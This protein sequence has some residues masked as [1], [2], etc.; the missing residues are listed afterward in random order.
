MT[1]ERSGSTLADYLA[2]LRQRKLL[3]IV[4]AVLCAAAGLGFS[5]LQNKE[6]DATSS[7]ALRDLS[8][9]LTLLGGFASTPLTP[10]QLASAHVPLVTRNSVAAE[11]KT[12]LASPLTL[13]QL[14]SRV[15]VHVD[16]N[17][18]L[19]LISAHAGTGQQAAEIANAFARVDARRSTDLARAR[20]VEQGK[21]L[22]ERL[23]TLDREKDASQRLVISQQLER[24]RSLSAVAQPVRVNQLA[25]VPSSPSSPKPARNTIAGLLFGIFLGIALAYGREALDQRLRD[26]TQVRKLLGLPIVGQVETS[27]L[28]AGSPERKGRRQISDADRE[29]LRILRQNTKNLLLDRELRSVVVTSGMPQEGK[30]SVAAGIAAANAATGRRTLLIECDLRRPVL[31]TRLGLNGSPGLTDYLSGDATPQEVL[32]QVSPDAA[33]AGPDST[34]HF[35][36]ITAG[37]VPM[38]PELMLASER[39]RKLLADVAQVYDLVVIDSTPILPVADALEILPQVDAIL[40]CMRLRQ[41]TRDQANATRSALHR[42][43]PKPTGIVVTG[44]QLRGAQGYYQYYSTESAGRA[45]AARA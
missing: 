28:G 17:S 12:R 18:N 4:V 34:G 22:R 31:A 23:K 37:S 10:L 26:T 20:L 21:I 8:E 24:I 9:D 7:L 30:S 33:G 3:V 35:T 39:F 44:V 27:A 32:Q 1:D 5:A 29:S 41:T 6:Y 36:C 13:P 2:A 45:P 19:V 40:L 43:P 42:L 16:P 11:V 14:R 38:D 15:D 25:T